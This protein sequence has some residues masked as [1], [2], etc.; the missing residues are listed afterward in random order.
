MQVDVLGVKAAATAVGLGR[1][2]FDRYFKNCSVKKVTLEAE[3]VAQAGGKLISFILSSEPKQEAT[4]EPNYDPRGKRIVPI[5]F[6]IDSGDGAVSLQAVGSAYSGPNHEHWTFK[7]QRSTETVPLRVGLRGRK[8]FSRQ[9]GVPHGRRFEW[10]IVS[11][12]DPFRAGKPKCALHELLK[13]P[14]TGILT[15][16]AK[17]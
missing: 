11:D 2:T 15:R 8:Y 13:E 9:T 1:N 16:S 4:L 5:H 17:K 12:T 3:A 7:S 14:T 6:Q 10:Y